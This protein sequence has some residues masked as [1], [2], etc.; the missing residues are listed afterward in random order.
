ML[1]D[2]KLGVELSTSDEYDE[3]ETRLAE[4]RAHLETTLDG[5]D[6]KDLS[7]VVRDVGAATAEETQILSERPMK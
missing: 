6:R 5:Y 2:R 3:F 7:T 4:L 1:V